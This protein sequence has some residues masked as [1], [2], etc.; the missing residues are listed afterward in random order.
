VRAGTLTDWITIQDRQDTQ[1]AAGEPIAAWVDV[2][3]VKAD[4]RYLKGLEAI[5][6]DAPVSIVKASVRIRR[7]IPVTANMRVMYGAQIL[8]I[9]TV[10]PGGRR[11]EDLDLVCE[12]GANEG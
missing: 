10:L 7:G 1:D 11:K 3:T 9:Q 12:A 5:R 8:N 2:A 4:V 6:S